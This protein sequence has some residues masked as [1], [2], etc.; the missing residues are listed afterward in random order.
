MNGSNALMFHGWSWGK[1]KDLCI[2]AAI[3]TQSIRLPR[4]N[5]RARPMFDSRYIRQAE[6]LIRCLPEIGKQKCFALK[7]GTAINLFLRP[8][9]RLSVDIDL[10]Y[11]PLSGREEALDGIARALEAAVKDIAAHIDGARA[12]IRKVSG[13]TA[14]LGVELKGAHIKV[15]PNQVLRGTVYPP[16]TRELCLDAQRRFEQFVSVQTLSLPDLYGGKICA[17]LDRQH[18]RDLYDVRLLLSNEGFSPDIRRAFVVYLAS[19]DRP[20]NELL[21]PQLKDIR[22]AWSAEFAG[23]TREEISLETLYEARD[24]LIKVILGGLDSDE[25]RFLLS[26]KRGEPEWDALG[27]AHLKELPALQWK[28]KNIQKMDKQKRAEA[29]RRLEKVLR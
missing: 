25:K 19:H 17:A 18:P 6:L 24:E 4:Q 14:K 3:L 20:M 2:A 12:E 22:E 7:G 28:L 8:M 27:I 10:T 11:L 26:L 16:R 5:R 15:E 13:R 1:E 29:L 21:N 23:M 9:P